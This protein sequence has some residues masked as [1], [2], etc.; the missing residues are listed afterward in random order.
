M[1]TPNPLDL[2][3]ERGFVQ[4]VTDEQGLRAAFDA[5]S[6]T[7]YYGMDPTAPSLHLGN[8]IG[9]MAMAWLQ[10]S[11]HR[12]IALAGGGT[13]RIG[14]PSGRDTERQLLDEAT[15]QAN[16]AGL[17]EQASRFVDLGGVTGTA[18][19]LVDNHDW[20]GQLNLMDFLRDVGKVVSVNQ[21]VARDS[22]KRRLDSREEGLSF[23]EFCYQ[24]LQ[25]YDFAH[26]HAT[27]GCTLQIGGSDQWGNITAGTDLVRRLHDGQ[28]FG[29]VWPLLTTASGAKFGKSAGNAV[30]L[31][32]D[33]TPPYAYYQYWINAADADVQRYL[34]L[35]TFLEMDRIDAV[36]AAHAETPHRRTAQRTLA[37]EATRIVHGEE[38]LAEAVRAT[39]VLFGEEPFAG[40]SDAVLDEA[41][42]AA[43]SV[44]LPAAAREGAMTVAE[45]LTAAGAAKSGGEARRLVDQGG[46]RLNNVV[47]DDATRALAPADFATDTTIVIRVGKKRYFLGRLQGTDA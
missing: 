4:D 44:A 32:A 47:A 25:A 36:M 9:L 11:G 10:R 13:G 22:V 7:F 40:L 28:A 23:T 38:G 17:R 1:A 19:L 21:M 45:L 43:P 26:L 35:F 34:G 42:V 41:F 37:E 29:L 3:R 8:L 5:G 15:L 39:E 16:L 30:W 24:L 18:G 31:D 20:L 27:E 33:L 12:P 2:L 14:D 46:V 6:V